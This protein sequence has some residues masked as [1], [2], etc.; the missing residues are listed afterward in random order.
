M[1]SR[2]KELSST[3][4]SSQNNDVQN[5]EN[6][7]SRD[8]EWDNI[9]DGPENTDESD[10]STQDDQSEA[11]S[12]QMRLYLKE[13]RVPQDKDPLLYWKDNAAKYPLLIGAARKYLAIPAPSE[14]EFKQ[15]KHIT[16]DRISLK[17]ANVELLLFIKYN[18]RAVNYYINALEEAPVDFVQI[19][20]RPNYR[21]T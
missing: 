1:S 21:G 11:V 16:K 17:P 7:I 10:V 2:I 19:N 3:D 18:L 12:Q 9:L 14:R 13:P 8:K 4:S 6:F 15:T 20:P 5:Q